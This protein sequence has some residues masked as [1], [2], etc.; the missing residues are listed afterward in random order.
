M[1]NHLVVFN[2]DEQRYAL[3]LATIQ[4]VLCMVEVTPLPKAPEVVLGLVDL[5]G[6]LIPVMSMRIRLGLRVMETSLS[7]QIIVAQTATRSVG[8]LVDRV[9]GVVECKREEITETAVIVPDAKYVEGVLRMEDGILFIHN[10]EQFLSQHEEEELS[11]AL[12]RAAGAK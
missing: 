6:E 10:L 5:H 9:S 11:G 12:A 2:V 8:L 4:R 7:E 1:G 3:P